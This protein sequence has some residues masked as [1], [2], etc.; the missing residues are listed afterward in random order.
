[1]RLTATLAGLFLCALVFSADS[2][3]VAASAQSGS[4]ISNLSNITDEFAVLDL[5]VASPEKPVEEKTEPPKAKEHTIAAGETL[6][7]VAKQYETTWQRI[8]AKNVQ[9]ANPDIINVGEKFV[10]PTTDEQLAERPVPVAPPVDAPPVQKTQQPAR[11]RAQTNAASTA[12]RGSASGNTYAAGYCTW[13]AKSRRSDLPN[14]LG[15]ANTWVARASAQGISTGSTPVAGAI[16]QRG[17]HVVYVESVNADGSANISEMNYQALGQV[18]SRT[19]PGNYF[20]YI[21]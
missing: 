9:I 21:Y 8:Y 7:V 13:Y 16:G 19:V 1:M 2:P 17:M 20:Q 11:Q 18:T 14:N 3:K 6:T 4:V 10:V 5:V 15:N 12:S